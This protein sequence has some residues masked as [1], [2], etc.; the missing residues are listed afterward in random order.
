MAPIVI[1]HTDKNGWPTVRF[2]EG[3]MVYSIDER[4]ESDRVYQMTAG[5]SS[6]E[7]I[8]ALIGDS[9]IGHLGD[10]PV[11]EQAIRATLAQ[12]SGERLKLAGGDEPETA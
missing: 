10:R 4:T 1:W 7:E 2:T 3:V 8:A 9:E 5:I 6:P 12:H 11:V